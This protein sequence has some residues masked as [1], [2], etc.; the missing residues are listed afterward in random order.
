MGSF[1]LIDPRSNATVA[2]GMIRSALSDAEAVGVNKPCLLFVTQPAVAQAAED[3]LLAEGCAVVR[4]KVQSEKVLRALL[5]AGVLAIVEV[6]GDDTASSLAAR[7]SSEDVYFKAGVVA[8]EMIRDLRQRG[9]L[10]ERSA[11]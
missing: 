10:P 2:A 4:T 7:F 9:I 11:S 6:P 5:D 3:T 8:D 1:I